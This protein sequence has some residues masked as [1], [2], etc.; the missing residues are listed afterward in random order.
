[1]TWRPY[2]TGQLRV[3]SAFFIRVVEKHSPEMNS[4]YNIVYVILFSCKFFFKFSVIIQLFDATKRRFIH[5]SSIHPSIHSLI[6]S[7]IHSFVRSFIY[8]FNCSA[9]NV[10]NGG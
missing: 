3:V 8:S 6:H 4:F 1:M 10:S 5:D 2:V 9:K 7:F